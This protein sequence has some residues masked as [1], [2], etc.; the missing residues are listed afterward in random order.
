LFA[1]ILSHYP[2]NVKKKCKDEAIGGTQKDKAA[3]EKKKL[4]IM[5]VI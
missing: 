2:Q 5:R 3:E 4:Q 1:I